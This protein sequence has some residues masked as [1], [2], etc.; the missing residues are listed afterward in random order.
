[1]ENIGR[2]PNIV[3]GTMHGPGYS[4]GERTDR[5][6]VLGPARLPTTF[7]RIRVEW[8]AQTIRWYMDGACTKRGTPADSLA[9][10]WVFDHP[11]FIILNLAIGG[12]WPG[13]PD[14]TTSFP[15][16]LVVD[17]VHVYSR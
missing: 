6:A 5:G 7:T 13:S 12:S 15:Q 16:D 4:G 14:Q 1:M 9:A 3:H 11:F 2:E 10:R 8:D 17:W